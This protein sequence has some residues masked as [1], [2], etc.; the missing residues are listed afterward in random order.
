MAN[1]PSFG[2]P[3]RRCWCRWT[4]LNF[5]QAVQKR[6]RHL[7]FQGG[8]AKRRH[9]LRKPYMV[10][11]VPGYESLGTRREK[12]ASPSSRVQGSEAFHQRRAIF[13]AH[14]ERAR[15]VGCGSLL[16]HLV[17]KALSTSS[18][19][20][21]TPPRACGRLSSARRLAL[22]QPW[23]KVGVDERVLEAP[24]FVL[25]DRAKIGEGSPTSRPSF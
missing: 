1:D 12:N 14:G 13:T 19:A 24:P 22:A 16:C 2:C 17:G 7:S 18:W 4:T 10:F 8:N 6:V 15:P 21:Q 23:R 25:A 3:G 20:D 11:G 5:R 9:D